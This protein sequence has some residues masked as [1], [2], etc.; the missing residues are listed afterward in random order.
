M[1]WMVNATPRPLYPRERDP[2]PIV[3]ENGWALSP[4]WTSAEYFAPT[5]IRS[6]EH[7]ARSKPLYPL[8][9][10]GPQLNNIK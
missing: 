8:S 4:V 7:P 9:Y 10:P 5:G 1:E 2:V 3:Q 6:Q